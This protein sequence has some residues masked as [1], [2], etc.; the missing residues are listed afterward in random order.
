MR[1]AFLTCP[2]PLCALMLAGI[3]DALYAADLMPLRLSVRLSVRC[4]CGGNVVDHRPPRAVH[5][6]A[7]IMPGT[8]PNCASARWHATLAGP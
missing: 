6:I 1:R 2:S 5:H 7:V 4:H 3:A 8:V